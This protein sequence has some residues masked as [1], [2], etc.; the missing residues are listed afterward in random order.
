MKCNTCNMELTALRSNLTLS[1]WCRKCCTIEM[2]GNDGRSL[3]VY[4]S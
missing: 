1:Y 2:V 3:G 4:S